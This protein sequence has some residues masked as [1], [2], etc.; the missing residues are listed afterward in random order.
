MRILSVVFSFLV[1]VSLAAVAL[2]YLEYR[3]GQHR[4][5]VQDDW[6]SSSDQPAYYS[7]GHLGTTNPDTARSGSAGS[8]RVS[9]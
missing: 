1:A 5:Y 7:Y 6:L 3:I 4:I 8:G 2:I 9:P